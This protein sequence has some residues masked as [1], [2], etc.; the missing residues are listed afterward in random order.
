ML[1]IAAIFVIAA[2]LS[3]R[4]SW[5]GRELSDSQMQEYLHDNEKPRHIQHALSQINERILKG[6]QSVKKWYADVAS[7]ANHPLPE[8]R[9]MAAWVMGQDN[10]QEEFHAAL[11]SLLEDRHPNVRHNA[12]LGLVRFKDDRAHPEII[13]MLKPKTITATAYGTIELILKEEGIPAG[14]GAP[15]ARIKQSAGQVVEIRAPEDGRIGSLMVSDGASVQMGSPVMMLLPSN[16]Q[17]REALRALYCIGREEDISYIQPYTR[18]MPGLRD[19]VQKQA[20]ITL[21]AIRSGSVRCS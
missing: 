21:E 8:V 10:T 11:L 18:P 3:W 4:G 7:L 16:D 6:D 2:Y 17:A 1:V 15:L 13:E 14:A 9:A 19:D 5:F 12:A 20:A